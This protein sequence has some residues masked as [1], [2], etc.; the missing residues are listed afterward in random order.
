MRYTTIFGLDDNLSL[1]EY[2]VSLLCRVM[3]EGEYIRELTYRVVWTGERLL[4]E[5]KFSAEDAQKILP[6]NRYELTAY[7][8]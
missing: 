1:K 3:E 6:Q 7:D 4:K 2:D 5:W 8:F